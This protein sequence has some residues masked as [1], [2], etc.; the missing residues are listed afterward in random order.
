MAQ[1]LSSVPIL[2]QT[3]IKMPTPALPD[4]TIEADAEA[5]T[6][7]VP[8]PEAEAASASAS[9]S[10]AAHQS[11]RDRRREKPHNSCTFCRRRKVRCDRRL[12]CRTCVNKGIAFSC[13]YTPGPQSSINDAPSIGERIRQLETLVRSLVQQ[14]QQEQQ[15]TSQ[16]AAT[17]PSDPV[18]GTPA[19]SYLGG[20]TDRS[21]QGVSVGTRRITA[22]APADEDMR[23][24]TVTA[25]PFTHLPLPSTEDCATIS[26]P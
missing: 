16:M 2:N 6:E 3:D 5:E 20:T 13:T 10:E 17:S 26:S 11:S 12:P 7:P 8:E 24:T 21:P 18:T 19:F 25:S 14:Q 9:A 23:Q 15:Q 4:T 22:Q 1:P